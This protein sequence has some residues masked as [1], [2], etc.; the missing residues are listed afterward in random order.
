MSSATAA[1]QLT[2]LELANQLLSQVSGVHGLA[3]VGAGELDCV[4][5]V[6]TVKAAQIVAAVELG[7]RT[8]LRPS[9]ERP[10]FT[11]PRKG[12]RT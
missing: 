9:K 11:S 4:P 12:G 10:Q 6:G 5:G 3:R 1:R 2:A 8:L 7:R